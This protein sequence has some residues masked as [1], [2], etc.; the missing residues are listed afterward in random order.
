[1]RPT[2]TRS[3]P[4]SASERSKAWKRPQPCHGRRTMRISGELLPV[5]QGERVFALVVIIAILALAWRLVRRMRI[6]QRGIESEMF[7]LKLRA[8]IPREMAAI[9]KGRKKKSG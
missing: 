8:D 7:M 9:Y 2:H 3:L 5:T 4:R 6:N 1:M